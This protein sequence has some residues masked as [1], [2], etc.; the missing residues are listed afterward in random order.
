MQGPTTNIHQLKNVRTTCDLCQKRKVRCDRSKPACLRC[1]KGGQVCT[2]PADEASKINNEFQTL[3]SRLDLAEA[4]LAEHGIS[5]RS[6][7]N[8]NL[9]EQN[10]VSQG[11]PSPDLP[12]LTNDS[13]SG[14][15]LFEID[16]W[17]QPCTFETIA[18]SI[19]KGTPPN[20]DTRLALDPFTSP[21]NG[22]I[23]VARLEQETET[24]VYNAGDM[25]PSKVPLAQDITNNLS[26]VCMAGAHVTNDGNLEKKFYLET[27]AHLEAAELQDD[28]LV[29]ATLETAQTLFLL[30][31][32]KRNEIKNTLWITFS[33]CYILPR[34]VA[35]EA[36]VSNNFDPELFPKS[37]LANAGYQDKGGLNAPGFS[38]AGED[39]DDLGTIFLAAEI[40]AATRRHH[41]F[42][43]AN[44]ERTGAQEYN[45]CHAHE[46]LEGKI[47][48][49]ISLLTSAPPG[50]AFIDQLNSLQVL[51]LLIALGARII[52]YTTAPIN[53]KK[54]GF[55]RAV[56]PECRKIA[57][58][59]AND[60]C[61]VLAQ[62]GAL[63]PDRLAEF[64][65]IK[66]FAMP[67]LV[68]ATEAQLSMLRE[69]EKQEGASTYVIG[70]EARTSLEI[71]VKA[72][73][74]WKDDVK[75]YSQCLAECQSY[76]DKQH[77]KSRLGRDYVG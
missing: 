8:G 38:A 11:I 70:R 13:L 5:L 40:F 26:A 72:M 20:T 64:R 27:R 4:R 74:T 17:S 21:P 25:V 67:M 62:T 57:T 31:R 9:L 58:L 42:T 52:L 6:N 35:Y 23:P 48:S 22:P 45:F 69:E 12:A 47:N 16:S 10:L 56:V 15:F 71:F 34:S 37:S 50:A 28:E 76:L 75:L 3:Q 1:R 39:M 49:I 43:A 51:A 46:T 2:Y 24:H 73:D 19:F 61:D 68:L 59:A 63:R 44:V 66:I 36:L 29:F 53:S 65:E 33:L 41:N 55:L 18:T 60:M 77:L 30:V 32:Q 14:D 7:P 54:A